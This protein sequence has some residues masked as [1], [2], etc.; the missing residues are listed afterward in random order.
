MACFRLRPQCLLLCNVTQSASIDTM[1]AD[2][3]SAL[4]ARGVHTR[5]HLCGEKY[6]GELLGGLVFNLAKYEG[7]RFVIDVNCKSRVY[8][9]DQGGEAKTAFDV[10]NI[11]RFSFFESN[12][13]Y[14]LEHLAAAPKLSAWSVVDASH[15]DILASIGFPADRVAFIPHAGPP[16]VPDVLPSRNRAIDVM[17][18]GNIL[19][20]PDHRT[21]LAGLGLGDA[22]AAVA[23]EA[24]EMAEA[25][26]GNSF[27]SAVAGAIRRGLA[28]DLRRE[29][30]IALAV[31]ERLNYQ[32]RIAT[33]QSIRRTPVHVYGEISPDVRLPDNVV[34]KGGVAFATAL[35]LMDNAKLLLN[36]MPFRT[37]AHERVFYGLSRGACALS[38]RSSLL[39]DGAAGEGGV[40]FRSSPAQVDAQVASLV[41]DSDGLDRRREAGRAW[42]GGRHTWAHRVPTII[43]TV[44]RTFFPASA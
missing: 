17:F 4:Q 2:I 8:V 21:W 27:A 34:A 16:P 30:R 43:E 33:L 20:Q 18:L 19:P 3:G 37:G 23:A 10:L 7:P 11:P 35:S 44:V 24:Y 29:S 12:P 6:D 26:D 36:F 38:D 25:G 41:A 15:R 40:V 42:Y 31:D 9:S 13:L 32:R 28:P 5:F 14:H 22:E 1:L 39:E